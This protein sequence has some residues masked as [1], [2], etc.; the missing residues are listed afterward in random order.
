MWDRYHLPKEKRTHVLGVARVAVFFAKQL[1]PFYPNI[2]EN[3]IRAAALLHDIDKHAEILHGEQHPDTAVRILHTEGMGEVASV[4]AA[5]SL[6]TILSST[7]SPKTIEEK[8]VYLA[9]KMVKY[10]V[11]TVDQRF[12]IWRREKIP[13]EGRHLLFKTYPLVKELEKELMGKIGIDPKDV[14]KIL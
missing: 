11:M 13:Q 1:K 3:L 12:S 14:K 2:Q 6:H 10:A 8:I 9:D 7:I 5:H 4:V